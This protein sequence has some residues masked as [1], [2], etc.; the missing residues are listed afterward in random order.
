MNDTTRGV[1]RPAPSITAEHAKDARAR[2]WKFIFDA[3]RKKAAEQGNSKT[4]PKSLNTEEGGPHDLA[5]DIFV[6]QKV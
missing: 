1:F 6:R 2:A 5:G 4:K 3:Y